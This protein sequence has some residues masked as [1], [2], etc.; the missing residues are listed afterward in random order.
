MA[1]AVGNQAVLKGMTGGPCQRG[2]SLLQS[3][4]FQI[5]QS[6]SH[7]IPASP[8]RY[9]LGLKTCLEVHAAIG[10]REHLWKARILAILGVQTMFL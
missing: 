10:S 2:L 8:R 9:P 7:R 6:A 3:L 5:A 1:I 4:T